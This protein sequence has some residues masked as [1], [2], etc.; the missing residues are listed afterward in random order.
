[1]MT[2]DLR[3][4][5]CGRPAALARRRLRP[6]VASGYL[7]PSVSSGARAPRSS[8]A[9]PISIF[10]IRR[11]SRSSPLAIVFDEGREVRYRLD[12][13]DS[14]A[15]SVLRRHA[16]RRR[17]RLYRAA[18]SVHRRHRSTHRAGPRKQPGGFTDE[19]LAALR[20]LVR[21]AGAARSRS[22]QLRRTASTLLDT[23]VGNRAGERILGGQIRRGHADTMQA[24]I[25]L[26]DLRGFTALVGPAAG[27]NRGRYPQSAI[28][29]VRCRRSG[30]MAGKC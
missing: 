9:R 23:Y 19:Q 21:A 24:A 20:S 16:R 6:D 1:M 8:S 17:H 2:R 5:G 7:R 13:P 15:L 12:D 14:Q 28:S 10:A 22:S 3:A 11:N 18:A 27:R 25:W 4:P 29:T 30:P 26:S